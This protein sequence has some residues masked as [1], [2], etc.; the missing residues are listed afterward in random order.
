[1]IVKF[2]EDYY[3]ILCRIVFSNICFWSINIYFYGDD[4]ENGDYDYENEIKGF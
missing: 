1:M 3:L 4:E 2:L